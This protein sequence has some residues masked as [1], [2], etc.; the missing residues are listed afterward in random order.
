M[1]FAAVFPLIRTRA[2]AEAFDY[3]VPGE[4]GA[5]LQVGSLVAVPL[6]AQTVIGVVLE[7]RPTTAHEGRMLPVRD[8]LDVPAVPGDLLELARQVEGYYLTSFAAALALVCPPMAALKVVRQY[9]LTPEGRA[10]REAGE[11]GLGEIA[12]LKLPAGPLTSL[13]ERYRRKG[14]VRTAYRVH[15]LGA[16]TARPRLRRGGETP[17]RLGPRQR[18]ALRVVEEAVAL[19]DRSLRAACGIS[20]PGLRRLIDAGALVVEE[21]TVPAGA[22]ATGTVEAVPPPVAAQVAR[23]RAC[24]RLADVPALLPEQRRA[25]HAVLCEA[26]PGDEVLVHGVTGSGKTEVYLQAAQAALEGGRSVL[27]LVPEIGLTGQTVA[28]VQERFAGERIAVLHSGLSSGERLLA[29][30]DVAA[31]EV[32]IVVG[33]RSAVFAPLADLGLVVVDEE[34]DTSYKQ[35]SEPAY[36]A[37]T[38]ARWRAQR[39]GAVVVLGSATPSVESFARVPLHA[40][41]RRR[42]DGSRPPALEIVDM[43]GQHAVFSPALAEALTAA[44]DAGDKA[45]LFLNRRGFASLLVCD[46]C[47]FTWECPRCDVTLTL[48]GGRGLRCRTCGH[49]E[50]AP[51]ICPGCGSTELVRHGFGTERVERE[52]RGLL[53]GVEL[54][55]LDS[56]VAGSYAR[57]RAVLERFAQPGARILI[58]TQ[59]IAKGHHFPDVTLVGV[60]NADL[61]LHFPDFRA[62]ERTFAMLVQVGGRSGRG[63][64]PGRVLVQTLSPDARPIAYA[65]AGEEERFYAE[66]VER[67]RELGYPPQTTLIALEVSGRDEHKVGLAGQ[68]TAERVGGL[69]AHGEL[70]LGPGPLWRE[71]GRSAC[72][73]L[74][75]TTTTGKTLD[76]LRAW[77]SRDRDRF[78]TRGVRLVPDVDPQWL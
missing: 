42:V 24:A 48:F 1:S 70:V 61:T 66:E 59:M 6:G 65:A 13:G 69:L 27:L 34:H 15:V 54:L 53:P 8:L 30:R 21:G 40:D 7:L 63:E 55:R 58:G 52:V 33:A 41:L 50:P 77:L 49:T 16:S 2:F 31:G 10:A 11:E 47:G 5:R 56:D 45:I 71:R 28:R 37:R 78:A 64:R 25:L 68:F 14:W 60:V 51:G 18:A 12:G 44:L 9:E 75:K 67:R 26:R 57:L 3:S 39:S 22:A 23:L 46:R 36:D 20:L 38:V 29:Y 35:E 62:E 74:V 4:L 17:S 19:D 73:V 72:R 76:V 32:R 43:R